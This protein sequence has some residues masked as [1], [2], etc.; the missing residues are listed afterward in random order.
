MGFYSIKINHCLHSGGSHCVRVHKKGQHAKKKKQKQE[1][2][3]VYTFYAGALNRASNAGESFKGCWLPL[4]SSS[5]NKAVGREW[6]AAPLQNQPDRSPDTWWW[7]WYVCL[8]MCL[9]NIACERQKKNTKPSGV[10]WR[11][12]FNRGGKGRWRPFLKFPVPRSSPPT[13]KAKRNHNL[14]HIESID[15]TVAVPCVVV[16]DFTLCPGNWRLP[17]LWA[18]ESGL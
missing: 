13:E 8:C 17:P 15:Q 2:S 10:N 3:C 16:R 1:Q 14:I 11:H 9:L 18:K 12:T 7:W 4:S 5:S 6:S